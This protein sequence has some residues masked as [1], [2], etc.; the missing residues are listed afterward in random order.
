MEP[1]NGVIVEGIA[2]ESQYTPGKHGRLNAFNDAIIENSII[3]VKLING[4]I[5]GNGTKLEYGTGIDIRFQFGPL[6]PFRLVR[7]TS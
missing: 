5:S 6:C 3:A 7:P 2:S 4:G 1:W